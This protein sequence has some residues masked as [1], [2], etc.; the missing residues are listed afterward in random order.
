MRVKFSSNVK[1]GDLGEA[2]DIAEAFHLSLK[3]TEE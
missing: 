2:L 1:T 3:G